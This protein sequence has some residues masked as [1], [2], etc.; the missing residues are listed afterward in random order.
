MLQLEWHYIDKDGESKGPITTAKGK[1]LPPYLFVWNDKNVTKW[2]QLKHLQ[3]LLSLMDNDGNIRSEGNHSDGHDNTKPVE[4]I[5]HMDNKE[6]FLTSFNP[7][8][9][10]EQLG[11]ERDAI[12]DAMRS[13]S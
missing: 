7:K 2:T 11:Y 10:L 1:Q 9:R 5:D 12:N 6:D 8:L 13:H 4:A 3:W